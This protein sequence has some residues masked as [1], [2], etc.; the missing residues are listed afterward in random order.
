MMVDLC[1]AYREVYHRSYRK[2]LVALPV[3]KVTPFLSDEQSPSNDGE[4]SRDALLNSVKEDL[5][6]GKVTSFE[7]LLEAMA[8]YVDVENDVVIDRIVKAM[9]KEIKGIA[10]TLVQSYINASLGYSSI[11]CIAYGTVFYVYK[12]Q[13]CGMPILTVL[14]THASTNEREISVFVH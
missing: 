6:A 11:M 12:Y 13:R 8:A 5:E 2:L 1:L 9:K 14:K 4:R 10:N 7:Q 3:D